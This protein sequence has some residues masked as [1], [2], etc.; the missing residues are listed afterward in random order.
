[1]RAAREAAGMDHE[2]FAVALARLI[3]WR[4]TPDAS[5]AGRSVWHRLVTSWS[6]PRATRLMPGEPKPVGSGDPA[7]PPRR[8]E[9]S[10]LHQLLLTRPAQRAS[11]LQPAITS[12]T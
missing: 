12:G 11:W 7:A 3:G 10:A 6:P 9:M 1:M 8:A 5:A 2:Q 4:P